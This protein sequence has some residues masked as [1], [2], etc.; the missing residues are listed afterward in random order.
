MGRGNQTGVSEFLLLGLSDQVEQQQLLFA[1]FLWIYL[2]GV[3]GS[4]LIILAIG[5]DPHL[6]TP[7][8]FFLTNLSLADVCFL[9]TTVPKMLANLQTNSK[10]IT[11]T[12]CLVQ[13]YFF[14]L[15]GNLD[16]FLLIG[17]AYDRY[18]AI[19]HP[20]HYTTI[21]SPCLCALVVAGSWLVSSLLAL[22]HTLLV[23]RLSFC[24]N[25]EILH[26]FCELYQILKLSC[27]STLINEVAVFVLAVVIGLAPFTGLLFSYTRIIFTILRIPSTGGRWKTFST[28]GS[29]LSM[30]SLFY[31]TGFGVCFSFMSTQATRQG[32]IA[33][34]MYSVVTPILNPF[35]YSLRNKDMKRALRNMFSRK[36]LFPQGP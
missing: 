35:I 36:I 24:S 15:F 9:S 34:V 18:M 3:L 11:Y 4:L 27:S 2:L 16:H 19:C 10:S 20:L 31:S 1:L 29:H 7:M 5:S 32:L 26:F 17:M 23:A 6:H 33:S 12:G 14:F 13:I 30:V 25:R 8:Y 22:T 28:C 21:M